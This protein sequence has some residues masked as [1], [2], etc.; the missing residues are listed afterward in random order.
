MVGVGNEYRRDDGFDSYVI[1]VLAE[2][3]TADPGLSGVE[4]HTTDGEPTRLLD[5]WTGAE[6]A[7]LVDVVRA[8]HAGDRYELVLDDGDELA[9]APSAAHMR[10]AWAAP[11]H[12]AGSSGASR[13]ASWCSPC[14]APSSVS[15]PG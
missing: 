12:W 2:R 13:A 10:S 8:D 9:T 1:A 14:P 15:A 4:L 11:S 3:Q 7:V 6:L 5:L